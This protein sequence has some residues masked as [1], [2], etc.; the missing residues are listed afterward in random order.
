MTKK[1]FA[2]CEVLNRYFQA[3]KTHDG[4]SLRQLAKLCNVSPAIVSQILNSKKLPSR[5]LATVLASV[6]DIDALAK[7]ELMNSLSRDIVEAKGLENSKPDE[8]AHARREVREVLADDHVLLENWLHI[9][10]LE[11]S[12]CANFSEDHQLLAKRF[13][14]SESKIR[15]SL[16]SLL[17]S[18]YLNRKSD[19]QL[20]KSIEKMRIPTH[21][22]RAAVRDFHGQMMK[23]AIAHMTSETS[24]Q[25][26]SE[27]L[28][29][30]FTVSV[31]PEHLE[32]AKLIL[33]KALLQIAELLSTGH[34]E[35]VYQLQA[36]LFPLDKTSQD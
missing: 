30:G 10:L 32:E 9:A 33:Q 24:A 21:R 29:T 5:R 15:S 18:G 3:L 17:R 27:R 6:L 22:S 12:G 8:R 11:A 16:E 26:F 2:S 1:K 14:V 4:L 20:E 23:K 31:N 36:Q 28:M 13:S 25:S 19:G 35:R 7:S 34:C